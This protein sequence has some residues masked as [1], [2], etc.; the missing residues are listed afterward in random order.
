[1]D[2]IVCRSLTKRF[3]NLVAVNGLDMVVPAGS[4]FGFL[5]HNGAGKTTTIKMLAGL[6]RPSAGA[7]EVFGQ[8]WSRASLEQV[9]LSPENPVFFG[10]M[11][12]REYLM[13]LAH[14]AGMPAHSQRARVD[15][16]LALVK[17]TDAAKRACGTYSRG[18]RQRLGLA[19]A[20]IHRPRILLLDEPTSALD[21]EGR[22][23]ILE[24]IVRLREQG[25][26]IF[27]SSHILADVERIAD[28]VLIIKNGRRVTGGPLSELLAEHAKPLID[29]DFALEPRPEI[30]ARLRALPSVAG[31]T[32]G[33]RRI[34]VRLRDQ[35]EQAELLAGLAGLGLA[36]EGFNLRR[37]TLEDVY[38]SVTANEAEREG[39]RGG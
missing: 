37:P 26:T 28:T 7:L 16:M 15:E 1:M 18:M 14:L 11:T 5:G 2:A 38:L 21:P 24:L 34:T 9:G 27:L 23:E 17:L 36:I 22:R 8:P 30:L 12:G 32:G 13:Y 4:V 31:A 10:W 6:S 29:I 19:A 39:G 33:G 3:G 35:H 25:L 20:L